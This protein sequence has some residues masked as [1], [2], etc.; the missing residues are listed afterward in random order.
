MLKA[1]L[2]NIS[3]KYLTNYTKYL[4]DI[5]KNNVNINYI[6]IYIFVL[7]VRVG[8]LFLLQKGVDTQYKHCYYTYGNSYSKMKINIYL[9]Q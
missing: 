4:I 7:V 8:I 9:K 5:E 3:K 2:I 6:Y 1:K